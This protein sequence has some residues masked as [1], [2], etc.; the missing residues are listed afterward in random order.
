MK[1]LGQ[2]IAKNGDS[3]LGSNADS[4]A[5]P[6][7]LPAPSV[8]AELVQRFRVCWEVSRGLHVMGHEI[9]QIGFSLV[10][11]GTH[12][13]GVEH[14]IPGCEHCR[15]VFAALQT[16]AAYL[17]PRERRESSYDV[18][19]FDQAIHFARE[20]D[21][22]PDVELA[23]TIYH[24]HGYERPVDACEIRCLEEMKQRLKELGA[25]ERHWSPRKEKR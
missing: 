24:R 1:T 4:L 11:Y 17:L 8:L 22:R 5:P 12:E 16:I 14:P 13:P 21:N 2:N 3:A 15:H 20:R 10:L 7:N 9:R 6:A 25:C 18:G 19:T 23:I